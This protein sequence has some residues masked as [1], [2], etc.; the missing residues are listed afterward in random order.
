MESTKITF[1]KRRGNF[2]TGGKT[3]GISDETYTKIR[4]LAE[5]T[6]LTMSEIATD[7]LGFAL[8]HSELTD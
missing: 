1:K 4:E 5:A 3:V 6:G 8:E 2:K 7:L